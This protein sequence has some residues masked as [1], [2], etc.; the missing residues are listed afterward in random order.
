MIVIY[1]RSKV[2]FGP[3]DVIFLRF[4]IN[5]NKKPRYFSATGLK[6]NQQEN[7]E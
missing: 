1:N 2:F 5:S 4:S 3:K 6:K 7:H